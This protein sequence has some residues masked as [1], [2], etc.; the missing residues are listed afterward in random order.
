[1]EFLIGNAEFPVDLFPGSAIA[2]AIDLNVPTPEQL[3]SIIA[4][5]DS[6][7][8]DAVVLFEGD[9]LLSDSEDSRTLSGN[10]GNDTLIGNNG[11]DTLL[12][13]KG[14][15]WLDGGSG[16][17]I[18]SG[19]GGNDMLT[20]GSGSD[21]FDFGEAVDE[22]ATS[23]LVTDY[24]DGEDRIGLLSGLSFDRLNLEQVGSDVR[25]S[26]TD[27][28][29][30]FAN[31]ALV[32]QNVDV[33]AIDESDF[34]STEEDEAES[35]ADIEFETSTPPLDID[36]D[37]SQGDEI[38]AVYQSF[39]SPHQEPGEEE[40]TPPGTPAQF[41]ST[42][43]SVPRSERTSRGHGVIRFAE[44]FS[45]AYVDV[46][47]EN[48]EIEDIVLFHIHCGRPDVLGPILVN[49][50]EA[51]SIQENFSD[52]GVFSVIVTNE[53]IEETIAAGEGLVGAFT[54]GCPIVPGLPDRVQTI[55]GMEYIAQQ[56]DLYFNLHTS[57][58]TF[59]GDIRG[60]LTPVES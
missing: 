28:S 35:H 10:Q 42:E 47:I 21:R 15:D 59:F 29:G 22:T 3:V 27:T 25:I 26:S 46:E 12:G 52:D 41:Q 13:G 53:Q 14:D 30:Q 58:Q 43:P 23:D 49:F 60:R 2:D 48:V 55:S 9:D 4:A 34:V 7:F 1:M 24:T 39:L 32:L 45:E 37:P 16:N 44:D 50:G 33:A 51:E 57:G 31:I 8:P 20:G 5:R 40:E 54:A 19:D 56:G 18:L 38:G 17:D 11:D 6:A 36:L